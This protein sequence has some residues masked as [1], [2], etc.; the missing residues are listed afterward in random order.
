MAPT[1]DTDGN[2]L[3]DGVG[4]NLVWDGENR[5]VELRD[6]SNAL[7]ASYTYDGQS[8]R[9][10]KV[11]TSLAPQGATE[12]IY[13]YDDRNRVATY[14]PDPVTSDLDLEQT[15]TGA[16]ISVERSKVRAESA[17]CWE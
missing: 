4:K 10:K 16:R 8:R 11:T 1:H 7:V 14:L 12:E 13:L 6:A 3:S 15:F 5:L 17:V 9:V 2:L